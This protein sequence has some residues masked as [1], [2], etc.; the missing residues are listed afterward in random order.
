M[1]PVMEECGNGK[2]STS[3][4]NLTKETKAFFLPFFLFFFFSLG[5]HPRHM[6][7]LRLGVELEDQL[8][9][10][11]RSKLGLHCICNLQ[12]SLGHC[13]DPLTY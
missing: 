5:L 4:S 1:S 9:D 6:E 13:P 12:C 3:G 2:T 7:V 8:S 11:A 10:Y